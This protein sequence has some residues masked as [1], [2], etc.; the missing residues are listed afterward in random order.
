MCLS[1]F[2]DNLS[3]SIS[4]L[5]QSHCVT[6]YGVLAAQVTLMGTFPELPALLLGTF[7]NKMTL[8]FEFHGVD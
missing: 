6:L 7:I 8:S 4:S 1:V 5:L 2:I 3:V